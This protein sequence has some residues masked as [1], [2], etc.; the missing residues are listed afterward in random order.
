MSV[1]LNVS[2]MDVTWI[3]LATFVWLIATGMLLPS[4]V[5][6]IIAKMIVLPIL[7]SGI[8]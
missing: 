5:L 1:F 8:V 3:V 7:V 4:I 6:L 2:L